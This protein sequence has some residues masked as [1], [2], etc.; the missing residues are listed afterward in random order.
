MRNFASLLKPVLIS[1]LAASVFALAMAPASAAPRN[2]VIAVDG[3]AV[4]H[5]SVHKGSV[6]QLMQHADS[7]NDIDVH[8]RSKHHVLRHF[9][10]KP[11]RGFSKGLVPL[12]QDY[13]A[14]KPGK[15]VIVA[16]ETRPSLGGVHAHLRHKI[17]IRVTR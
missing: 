15:A 11:A 1:A 9:A 12:E 13:K 3:P 17:Y 7:V 6:I 16:D 2:V 10:G 8:V 4:M 5:K 14:V